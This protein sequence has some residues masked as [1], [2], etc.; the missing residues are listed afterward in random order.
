MKAIVG[1]DSERH[2]RSAMHLLSRLSFYKVSA[3]LV[4][5]VDPYYLAELGM[6]G[7]AYAASLGVPETWEKEADELLAEAQDVAIGSGIPC[8][9]LRTVGKPSAA[10]TEHAIDIHADLIAI[11]ST[12]KSKYGAFFL[13]SVG[14]SLTIGASQSLLIAKQDVAKSGP[15]TAVFAIDGSEYADTCLRM[16]ARMEPKGIGRLVLVTAYDR[17]GLTD[18]PS[19]EREHLNELV[20]HLR[21]S[22]M[23][24]EAHVVEGSLHEVIDAMMEST[25][26]DLLVMG[27]RGH[28]FIDRLLVGSNSLQQVVAS[29][30][31]VLLL[32]LP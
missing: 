5:V 26:A 18:P 9:T 22:G 2:Y 1:I 20:A 13:G 4:H 32:R 19:K 30:H 14:R 10:L 28:G 15:L 24:A 3:E 29:P 8:T 11:G 21:E 25:E 17:L 23:N 7:P 12:H 16:F 27:A 6:V 31:S